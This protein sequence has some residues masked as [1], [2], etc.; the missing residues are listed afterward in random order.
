MRLRGVL[1]VPPRYRLV[2]EAGYVPAHDDR[3]DGAGGGPRAALARAAGHQRGRPAVSHRAHDAGPLAALAAPRARRGAGRERLAGDPS[4]RL[5]LPV[6]LR[7]GPGG[8]NLRRGADDFRH[9]RVIAPGAAD[10][11]PAL[12]RRGDLP[13][14]V[15]AQVAAAAGGVPG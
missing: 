14:R 7:V 4:L 12:A 6:D 9:A 1:F 2:T 10:R 15:R 5:L 13:D 11:G 8:G 3:P